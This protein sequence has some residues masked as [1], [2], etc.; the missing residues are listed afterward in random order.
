M[1]IPLTGYFCDGLILHMLKLRRP[2]VIF[3]VPLLIAAAYYSYGRWETRVP[4]ISN[5]FASTLVPGE[6]EYA[7]VLPKGYSSSNES[8]PAILYLH[9]LGEVGDD[10]SRLVERGLL[11]EIRDGLEIPFIVIA[12]QALYTDQ[13]Q[14]GWKRNEGDILKVLADAQQRY[15]IDADRI[16]LTGISMGGIGSFYMSSQHPELFAAVAPIAGEGKTAWVAEYHGLPFWVF[17]GVKDDVISIDGAQE[18]VDQMEADS[19]D[20][21]FTPYPDAEH[22]SWT[23]TYRNLELYRWFL[24]HRR[25][26]AEPRQERQ[27]PVPTVD[28]SGHAGESVSAEDTAGDR[29]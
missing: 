10:L 2:R 28:A 8:W 26:S 16:Y 4:Y 23:P 27:A 24:T 29:G 18:M 9:G 6:R 14:D 22:D 5:S 1:T 25:E 21:R 3:L 15:R 20:V 13:Y 17:H 19:V 11:A 7:V 12:P